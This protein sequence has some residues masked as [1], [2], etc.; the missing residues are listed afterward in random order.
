[1]TGRK[2]LEDFYTLRV[3][4]QF[5]RTLAQQQQAAADDPEAA[6][7]LDEMCAV[8]TA[9]VVEVAEDAEVTDPTSAN[10]AHYAFE[11]ER[12]RMSLVANPER[13]PFLVLSHSFEDFEA[14]RRECGD[15]LLGFLGALA[16]LRDEMKLTAR[17]VRSLRELAG[18]LVFERTGP[19]GFALR[20]RFGDGSTAT[21][22][23]A[24]I[25]I[26]QKIFSRLRTGEL[27]PQDAFLD[28][29]VEIEGDM[30]M[31][32]GLALTAASPD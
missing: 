3:P 4:D 25:R 8:R 26:D 21:E 31:A 6:R 30:E 29:L 12:G 17:R 5:N 13:L 20:A 27:E 28:G 16:G 19:G 1:M 14:L 15:S 32:V 18:A 9:I 23:R 24:W 2:D 7:I 11:I 22:P 10:R